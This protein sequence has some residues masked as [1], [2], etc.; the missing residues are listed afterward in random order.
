MHNILSL[1]AAGIYM[2]GAKNMLWI[3]E[4]ELDNVT[5]SPDQDKCRFL[6]VINDT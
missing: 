1:I 5:V 3:F 6:S 2:F 4:G